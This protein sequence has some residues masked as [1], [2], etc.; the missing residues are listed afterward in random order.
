[1]LFSRRA[2]IY[3]PRISLSDLAQLQAQNLNLPALP[4]FLSS[5]VEGIPTELALI[6]M[7][8]A[9]DQLEDESYY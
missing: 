9:A 5:T 4:T 2:S 7:H 3:P 1:M 8:I 6:R